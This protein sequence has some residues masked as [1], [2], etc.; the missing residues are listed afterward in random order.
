M[1]VLFLLPVVALVTGFVLGDKD[2]CNWG[3][4]HTCGLWLNCSNVDLAAC[5]RQ[6]DGC[7]NTCG[8]NAVC[9]DGKCVS[10]CG[11]ESSCCSAAPGPGCVIKQVNDCIDAFDPYCSQSAWDSQCAAEAQERC[12]LY[13]GPVL[14][15]ELVT[16]NDVELHDELIAQLF[17]LMS[18]PE[19]GQ[20]PHA[21]PK[22]VVAQQRGGGGCPLNCGVG[23]TCYQ[24][25]YNFCEAPR[26]ANTIGTLPNGRCMCSSVPN[27]ET[28]SYLP[29]TD[30]EV[31]GRGMYCNA[32]NGQ[33]CTGTPFVISD[34]CSANQACQQKGMLCNYNTGACYWPGIKCSVDNTVEC[35]QQCNTYTYPLPGGNCPTGQNCDTS[36]SVSAS[37]SYGYC[38]K[39][40]I[41][42]S[43]NI[44]TGICQA[45]GVATNQCSSRVDYGYGD[46]LGTFYAFCLC[47]PTFVGPGI[48]CPMFRQSRQQQQRGGS[49][50]G[51]EN[52]EACYEVL[53]KVSSYCCPNRPQQS[54]EYYLSACSTLV[55]D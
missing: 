17:S 44:D 28:P 15:R 21:A 27:P 46:Y 5:A 30:F 37:S 19:M 51:Q 24:S 7:D 42:G 48:N 50:C 45:V 26:C 49:G 2:P 55:Q 35:S 13:C 43:G 41:S 12:N 29:A 10:N 38:F 52:M 14:T 34:Y 47:N 23:S 40:T 33:L 18:V 1:W 4:E 32:N 39:P 6:E 8:K 31:C 16:D 3:G 11:Q 20:H 25:T 54:Y 9:N 36:N 22:S 53:D